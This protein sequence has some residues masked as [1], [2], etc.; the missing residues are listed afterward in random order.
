MAALRD[1][2]EKQ[3]QPQA[4][5]VV[6]PATVEPRV[7]AAL[8]QPEQQTTGHSVRAPIVKQFTSEQNVDSSSK[9]STA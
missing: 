8:L 1:K 7:T 3:Q 5:Q 6:G 2:T 9:G 4:H